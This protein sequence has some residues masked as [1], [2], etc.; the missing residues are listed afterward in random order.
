MVAGFDR[1]G[2][3]G[4]RVEHHLFA[5]LDADQKAR[6]TIPPVAGEQGQQLDK[7]LADQFLGGVEEK[8]LVGVAAD[9]QEFLIDPRHPVKQGGS[10]QEAEAEFIWRDDLVSPGAFEVVAVVRV[11]AL[12]GDGWAG[13]PL[14]RCF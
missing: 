14:C 11:F 1:A 4:D 13:R 7:I 8:H 3:V 9:G 10:R 12:G 5:T 2:F 6:A